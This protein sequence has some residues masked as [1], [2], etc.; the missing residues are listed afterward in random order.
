MSWSL[1]WWLF[2]VAIIPC[3]IMVMYSRWAMNPVNVARYGPRAEWLAEPGAGIA[4]SIVAGAVY[5]A[6]IAGIGGFLF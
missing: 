1:H 5:A 6:I 2:F 4:G 3:T